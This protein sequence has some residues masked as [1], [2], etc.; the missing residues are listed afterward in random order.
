MW[1]KLINLFIYLLWWNRNYQKWREENQRLASDI[2]QPQG[3]LPASLFST[4]VNEHTSPGSVTLATLS[5]LIQPL[6]HHP[7]HISCHSDVKHMRFIRFYYQPQPINSTNI[8][9][10]ITKFHSSL[11]FSQWTMNNACVFIAF[12][13]GYFSKYSALITLKWKS[14][15]EL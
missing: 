10:G 7:H 14:D 4:G 8:G 6:Y 5:T 9:A 1:E 3:H 15:A 12:N 13:F 11:T 2:K